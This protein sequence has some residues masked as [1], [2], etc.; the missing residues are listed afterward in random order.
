MLRLY[1]EPKS[2]LEYEMYNTVMKCPK[3]K[4]IMVNKGEDITNN[5]KSGKDFKEYNRIVY[6]CIK[7]DVWVS[8]ET[9]AN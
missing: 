8:I 1:Q 4:K 9:P 2:H 5:G 6:W 7:D 3:C